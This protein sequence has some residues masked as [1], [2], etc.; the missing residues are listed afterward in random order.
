LPL[1]SIALPE[2][3]YHATNPHVGTYDGIS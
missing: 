2:N 1:L 3:G